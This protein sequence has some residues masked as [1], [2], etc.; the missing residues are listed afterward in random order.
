MAEE[1]ILT[2]NAA[3][4]ITVIIMVVLG[5]AVLGMVAQIVKMKRNPPAAV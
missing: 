2:W 5:F 4:W 1:T 3:N